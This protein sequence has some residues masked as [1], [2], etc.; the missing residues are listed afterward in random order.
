MEERLQKIIANKGLCSRREAEKWIEEGRV[1]V[2][3]QPA[4]LGQKVDPNQ[5]D[6]VVN[7]KS[8]STLNPPKYVVAVN[9]P[10]GYVCSNQDEFAEKLVF[11]LLPRQMQRL[12]LFVAGRL[13]K[14]S[15]GL[16]IITNDGAFAQRLTHPS[17]EIEKR[18]HVTFKP[19]LGPEEF[20]WFLQGQKVEG[21]HLK[22]EKILP[23]KKGQ[24]PYTEL[25]IILSHGKKREIRRLF[26]HSRRDVKKLQRTSIGKFQIRGIPSGGHRVLNDREIQSLLATSRSNP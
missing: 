15:T 7:G 21:E 10:R 20:Q 23:P 11:E 12:K 8:I 25:D 19:A 3:G 26:K 22:F 17:E 16:V 2:D 5:Q 6:I 1:K 4:Q 18:Y 24:A 14:D 9:K 13:D